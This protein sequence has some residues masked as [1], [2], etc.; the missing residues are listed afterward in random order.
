[1]IRSSMRMLTCWAGA[2]L[3]AGAVHAADGI[4]VPEGAWPRWQLR[5]A[6]AAA[7]PLTGRPAGAAAVV[8]DYYF[9]L[10]QWVPV[11][12]QGGLRATGGV[13]QAPGRQAGAL[14]TLS[15]GADGPESMPY[16]GLG[17]TR[18]ATDRGWGFSADLGLVAHNPG[19]AVRL[20]RALLGQPQDLEDA[21]RGL[22][23]APMLQLGVR[24]SF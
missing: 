6:L 7:E 13:V 5:A 2:W 18:M 23:L 8:G 10:A 11:S 15:L 17:Y 16:L 24:Y 21:V 9:G 3:A 20:G 4:S 1:M 12:P 22:R 19:Q 14:R